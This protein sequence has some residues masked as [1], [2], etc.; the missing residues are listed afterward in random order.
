MQVSAVIEKLVALLL[1]SCLLVFGRTAA[2]AE[3]HDQIAKGRYIFAV[4]GGCACHTEPK[5]EANVGGRPFPILFGKVYSTNLT[6]D[7]ETGLGDWSDQQIQ[8]AIV[9][10]VRRDGSKLLPV[11]PFEKYSGIAEEDLRALIAYLRTFKPVKKS[12]PELS[13]WVPFMRNIGTRL[14]LAVFGQFST[15]PVRAPKSGLERGRYLV[16]QIAI[17][18]D[19]HTPRNFIGAPIRA[20]YLAGMSE[21]D[22]PFQERAPNITPDRET[23]IG[24]WKREDIVEL[25]K[26]ATKPD[27]DNVQGLMYEVIQGVGHG[28]KDMTKEDALAIADYLKS[29][30]PIR[31]KV[32]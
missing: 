7:K 5:Q 30:P 16:E 15:A 27:A 17:C 20:M 8:D 10:G 19:C 14:F 12:T 11:M 18:G 22:S 4:A 23:G 1:S 26:S 13:T 28:Y 9:R 2:Q 3:N 21:K 32:D 25:L 6:Q 29:I 24:D 31:H